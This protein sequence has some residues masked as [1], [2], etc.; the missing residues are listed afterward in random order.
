MY[1]KDWNEV[2]EFIECFTEDILQCIPIENVDDYDELFEILTRDVAYY[3]L[4]VLKKFK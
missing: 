1:M 3:T 4:M 2:A